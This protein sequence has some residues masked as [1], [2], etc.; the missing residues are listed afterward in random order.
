MSADIVIQH[1]AL[2][3]ARRGGW[4]WGVD[5]RK[6]LQAAIRRV[7]V[8]IASRIG[9][10]WPSADEHLIT[11][12]LRLRISVRLDELLALSADSADGAP[13]PTAAEA[14][15]A[16]RIEPMLQALV[17]RVAGTATPISTSSAPLHEAAGRSQAEFQTVDAGAVLAVLLG[18]HRQADSL[19]ATLLSFSP[20]ALLSW[21]DSLFQAPDP[22]SSTSFDPALRSALRLLAA[23]LATMPLPLPGGRAAS[24]IRRIGL[25]VRAANQLGLAPADPLLTEALGLHPAFELAAAVA[26]PGT[27]RVADAARQVPLVKAPRHDPPTAANP[28]RVA[29]AVQP[30]PSQQTPLQIDIKVASALPFLLLGPLSR[31]G[32]L[33]VLSAVFEATQQRQELPCFALALARKVLEPPRRGSLRS[34]DALTAASAFAGQAEAPTDASIAAVARALAAQVSPLDTVV[35]NVLT[36]GHT[37]GRP[38]LLQ[39]APSNG[40]SGWVLCE[41]DGLFPIAWAERIELLFPRLAALGSELLLVPEAA[42][43]NDLLDRLDDAGFRFVTDAA[44]A[45]DRTWR[46]LHGGS[47]RVWSNQRDGPALPLLRTAERLAPAAGA[48]AALWQTLAVDR[49]GLPVASEAAVER[50]LALAAA[51]ALGTIAWTLWREREAVTP[52]L[53]LQRFADLDARISFRPDRV[54]VHLPLG[55]RFTDLKQAGLLADVADVPW[56]GGRPLQFAQG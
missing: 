31:T 4:C 18:W 28:Q 45:R 38:L 51:L 15:L 55:R 20:A 2:R 1:C 26:A 40:Q 49:P 50:S 6:L 14:A 54:Q 29:A 53:A 9:E 30:Q 17:R 27:S 13:T 21:H 39:A 43:M 3:I 10:L 44:P 19:Q 25:V 8:L 35:G 37:A 11:A 48:S 22:P 12:P 56:F 52:L 24:L 41:D 42:V 34:A 23:E 7:P 33:Q 47:L 5:P 46:A 32:Y 16:Q 36:E